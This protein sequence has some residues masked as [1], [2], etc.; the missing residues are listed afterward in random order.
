MAFDKLTKATNMINNNQHLMMT[1][2][3]D[4]ECPF[5]H[6]TRIAMYEKN[7]GA[8]IEYIIDGHWPEDIAAVNQYGISPT[9]IDRNLVLFNA[10]II[11]SYFD[12]RFLQPPLMPSE[13]AS[14]AQTRMMLYRIDKDW[15][16]HWD[17]LNGQ[18]KAKMTKV[19]KIIQ[20]DLTLLA[21]LFAKS[22]F[23]MGD[24]FSLLDCSLAPLLWRL[25]LLGIKLPA[26]AKTIEEYAQRI[27][28]RDSFQKSL[29]NSERSMR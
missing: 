24:S 21:P 20:E 23:F 6:R 28:S 18:E 5:C 13:P 10:D 12:E 14:R 16:S 8:N 2:Y 26:R 1:L 15:Y 17:I 19:R 4:P 25:P 22:P 29:S 3:S 27:F 9:L 11:I 7:I